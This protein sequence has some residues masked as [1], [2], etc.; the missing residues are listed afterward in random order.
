MDIVHGGTVGGHGG[1]VD[2]GIIGGG[3]VHGGIVGG[4]GGIVGGV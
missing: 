2:E 4:S 3:I 1:I